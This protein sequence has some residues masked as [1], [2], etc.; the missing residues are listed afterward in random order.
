VGREG[1]RVMKLNDQGREIWFERIVWSYMPTHWKGFA[2]MVV[3]IV[4]SLTLCF[5]VDRYVPSLFALPLIGGW[6][7]SMWFCERHAPSHRK[8]S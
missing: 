6:A 7:L 8:A 2:Y 4:A 3:L 5:A 1:V